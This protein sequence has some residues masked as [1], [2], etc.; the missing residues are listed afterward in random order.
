M[1]EFQGAAI[2]DGGAFG[3]VMPPIWPRKGMFLAGIVVQRDQRV[4]SQA[5]VEAGL[6]CRR[7]EAVGTGNVEHERV[8]DAFGFIEPVLDADP[9]IADAGIRVRM[10]GG[11]V[12]EQ[13]AEAVA[14][15][16]GLAGAGVERAQFGQAGLDIQQA[17]VVVEDTE[18]LEGALE[19]GIAFAIQLDPGFNA[20]EQVGAKRGEAGAGQPVAE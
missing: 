17:G 13:T 7:G 19:T 12:G 15:R 1:Q 16:A 8:A 9:I 10:A 14:D 4:R 2:G 20:P 6:R 5:F 11:A 18:Q 3:V